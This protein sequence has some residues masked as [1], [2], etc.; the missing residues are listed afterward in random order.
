MIQAD[1]RMSGG[2][3]VPAS[4]WVVAVLSLLWNS[5][6]CYDYVMSESHN[7][8][9]LKMVPADIVAFLAG[10]PAWTVGAWAFGVW[11]SLAGS[12]LLCARMRQ[13]ALA[14]GVSLAGAVV[15][16]GWQYTHR[17]P[18]AM[19]AASGL[20]MTT[21]IFAVIGVLLWYARRATARGWLR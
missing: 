5:F 20:G 17:P 18:A 2:A 7:A 1:G 13:A 11:G 10:M 9:Y 15:S 21:G 3:K 14:F 4:F 12:L 6:G 16:F 8:A 19:L